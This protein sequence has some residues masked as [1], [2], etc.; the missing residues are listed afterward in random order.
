MSG[1]KQLSE[2]TTE[3]LWRLFPI[4]LVPHEDKWEKQFEREKILLEQILQGARI[5]HIGSTAVKDIR[6][7][8]IV[9]ILAECAD[10]KTARTGLEKA[11][12][13]C[14]SES[15]KR[16]S[17]NKGYTPTGFATE[18]FYLHLRGFG[19]NDEIYFCVYL[20][21][22]TEAAREYELLKL[23]LW[24]LYEFDRD[25]YTSGKGNF[26]KNIPPRPKACTE[27]VCGLQRTEIKKGKT[28]PRSRGDEP[29][30]MLRMTTTISKTP[31]TRG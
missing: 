18:V 23:R 17:F 20:K 28:K 13:I 19:D 2:M 7:K 21:E 10:I 29:Q 24:K 31:L 16:M 30:R 26:V 14:M 15:E 8:P 27:K 9:D 1:L 6:A 5:S 25:A 4:R 3:E 11:G 22:H 12:W